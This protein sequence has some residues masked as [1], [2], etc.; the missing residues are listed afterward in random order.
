MSRRWL[1][2]L[3]PVLVLAAS[4]AGAVVIASRQPPL[5]A[6]PQ[7]SPPP[8]VRVVRAMPQT[9]NL[10]VASQGVVTARTEID[11]A[12]E[13]SG[14]VIRVHPAFAVGG[15]FAAGE[16]L[17]ALDPRDY[18]HAIIKAEAQIVEARRA[19]AQEEAAVIQ[20][21]GEW[22]ALGEGK[23]TPLALHEPQLAE[24]RARLR[25]AEAELAD[26]RLR[27]ARCELRAPFAGRIREVRA[28]LGQ[29]LAA[30]DK[31]AR[32]YAIDAVEIRLPVAPEHWPYLDLPREQLGPA[33][34]TPGPKVTLSARWGGE[35]R[36][37]QGRIIRTE[38]S[39]EAA[40]GLLY[41]V[42]EVRE[43]YAGGD[44]PLRVGSFVQADIEG[45][46]RAGVFVL[47]AGVVDASGDTLVVDDHDRLRRRRVEV[48]RSD[49]ERVVVRSGLT[50]GERVVVAG[51]DLPV[52]GMAV[53]VEE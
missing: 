17:L 4:V 30:G 28:G 14:K 25:A 42:A 18:D 24:A 23:P 5:T 22:Q 44:E 50:A 53:R 34:P 6:P 47:P 46:P 52:E 38:G 39:V 8:R 35:F 49:A 16:V 1:K 40:T 7:D 9:L 27:R 31:P 37:W 43:P 36:H 12:A 51:V 48:L 41:L 3:L 26:T 33:R 29:F 45:K 10:N 2:I 32:I 13:V 20:A 21:K 11:L 19:I 15:F